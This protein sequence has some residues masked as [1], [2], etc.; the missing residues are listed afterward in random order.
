MSR[1][2]M[3][4]KR[5]PEYWGENKE[6]FA[7]QPLGHRLTY[8][9]RLLHTHKP[10]GKGTKRMQA[11][12]RETVIEKKANGDGTQLAL[13]YKIPIETNKREKSEQSKSRCTKQNNKK[14]I[15]TTTTKR[16]PNSQ[17]HNFKSE[18]KKGPF[19]CVRNWKHQLQTLS[20]G[21]IYSEIRFSAKEKGNKLNSL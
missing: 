2:S 16:T 18:W 3:K 21:E 13:V 9:K 4:S 19:F 14:K 17:Q 1:Y 7:Y 11:R 8:T 5:L 20:H 10:S 15:R 12:E 6:K